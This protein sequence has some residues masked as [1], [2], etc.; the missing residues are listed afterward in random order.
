VNCSCANIY[1]TI[2]LC[3]IL[4]LEGVAFPLGWLAPL[5]GW[6][7]AAD[8]APA[9]AIKAVVDFRISRRL[10]GKPAAPTS[11]SIRNSRQAS[12]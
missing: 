6:A 12:Q 1:P 2:L 4:P 11:M 3:C 7:A 10:G 5:I 9:A 8:A